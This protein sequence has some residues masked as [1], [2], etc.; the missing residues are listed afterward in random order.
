M[1]FHELLRLAVETA[2][3]AIV[4]SDHS[5]TIVLVNTQTEKPFG[6]AREELVGQQLEVLVPQQSRKD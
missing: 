3:M 2:P 1:S 5:G 4:I 6:Y